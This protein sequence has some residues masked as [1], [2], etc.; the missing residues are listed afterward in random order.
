MLHTGLRRHITGGSYGLLNG[1]QRAAL[2]LYA[3]RYHRLAGH[4]LDF[5]PE[6]H[7]GNRFTAE[8]DDNHT[9]HVGVTGKSRQ[10]LL[11]HFRIGR[12]IGTS[13]IKHDIH[14]APHLAGDDAAALT[15]AGTGR[16][17]QH[18]VAD[19][20]TSFRPPVT[21]ELKFRQIGS[22]CRL[23][24]THYKGFIRQL[25]VVIPGHAEQVM[26][27]HPLPG[28]NVGRHI[29]QAFA[30]LDC[31]P[32]FRNVRNGNLMAVGN[33]FESRY[34]TNLSV[35]PVIDGLTRFDLVQTGYNVIRYVHQ[36]CIDLHDLFLL[37]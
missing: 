36:Q 29:A 13:S 3:E 10:H 9:V 24:R 35:F 5:F 17:D 18:M 26:I 21:P 15:A 31:L 32:A 23:L 28:F 6:L 37:F 25:A 20:G 19:T 22:A 1:F 2:V 8:T 11:T 4:F 33:V 27:G 34:R 14:C 30:V 16:K 7:V 12:H